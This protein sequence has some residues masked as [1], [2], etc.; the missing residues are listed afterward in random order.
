MRIYKVRYLISQIVADF[1]QMSSEEF[2]KK[3][4]RDELY[5]KNILYCDMDA[6]KYQGNQLDAFQDEED[7]YDVVDI[8]AIRFRNYIPRACPL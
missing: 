1:L 6:W 7:Y 8:N 3:Y 2:L 4:N 5:K